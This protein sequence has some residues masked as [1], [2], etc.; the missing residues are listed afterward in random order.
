MAEA[1]KALNRTSFFGFGKSQKFEDA[2]EA[3]VKAGNAYK[4]SNLSESAGNAFLR[5]A[6]SYAKADN[7]STEVVNHMVEAA[8]NFKKINPV[9]AIETFQHAIELYNEAG[10]F[11]MSARYYKEIAEIFEADGNKTSA[12]EAYEQAA[13]MFERDNKKS[14]GSACL[15]KVAQ[16]SAEA[17]E[18]SKAAG[19]YEG[20]AKDGLTSR[21]GAF[22]AKGHFT[23]ALLCYLAL[24][25]TVQVSNKLGEYK[26]LDHSFPASRECGFIEKLVQATEDVNVEDF[27]DACAD[28]DR[29]TPLDALKTSLLLRAKQHIADAAGAEVDLS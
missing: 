29:I 12:A 15:L 28:F 6:E 1:D 27:S 8:N 22:G 16:F 3:F 20:A 10:R 5:A 11:G 7:C 18:L 9:R 21:L 13:A 17:G 2:G 14:N 19:I 4:L 23:H 26:N 24:G 25:D